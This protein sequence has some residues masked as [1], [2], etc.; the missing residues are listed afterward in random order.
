LKV[1]P[2]ETVYADADMQKQFEAFM[3]RMIQPAPAQQPAA[4]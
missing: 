4:K 1:V 3:K 2:P